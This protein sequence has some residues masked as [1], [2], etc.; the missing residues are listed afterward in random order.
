MLSEYLMI[1]SKNAHG[2]YSMMT[3]GKIILSNDYQVIS[4]I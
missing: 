3:C 1:D 2:N 4:I